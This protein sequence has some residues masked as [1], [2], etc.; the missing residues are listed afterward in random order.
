M[1][2]STNSTIA[3]IA[4]P[5]GRG[6]IGIIRV[7][8]PK[9]PDI[10]ARIVGKIPA[11]RYAQH[12][13]F[14]AQDGSVIDEGVVL[15]FPA[16]HSFTGEDVLELQGH[17]GPVV[18]DMLLKR[19]LSEG[20]EQARP[21]EF[22]ERAF[23]NGK[24]DLA[25]AEAIADLIDAQ[26]EQAARS[27][28]RSL[29]GKFSHVINQL[30]QEITQLRMYVEAAIDFPTEEIDFLAD[31]Q[32]A[33]ELEKIFASITQVEDSAQ[34]GVML[35]EGM[36]VVIAGK[37]NVGKSSLLNA[38]S[39]QDTAIVADIPG[40]TRDV[41]RAHIQI[42]GLPLHIIDTAGLRIS[43]DPVEKEGIKRAQR[44]IQQADHVMLVVDV[45]Q[46]NRHQDFI[47]D[48]SELCLQTIPAGK[49]TVVLNKI[50]V[51][52]ISP[53]V[54]QSPAGY[55]QIKLSAKS[56]EGIA[57]LRA[58]LKSCLGFN[59]TTENTFSA[60]R[61]HVDAIALAKKHVSQAKIQLHDFHAGELMAEELRLAQNALSEITGKFLPDDLLG[62]IF[63]SFCI[64]K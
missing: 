29:Q 56:G 2:S 39:G 21:G 31:Q 22:S 8:G 43:D 16:P 1:K 64:G 25:Q 61:R 15:Y 33:T 37:P 3:A 47:A 50:D 63:S 11:P 9:A 35:R 23:L 38:L 28:Q 55:A 27:A 36:S 26:S 58:H 32:I 20:V 46:E 40:T 5:P 48:L 45:T 54:T 51:M 19:I 41:L 30:V 14:L 17:G 13:V 10:A 62:K 60:R 57:L 18:L 4:T 53:E 24:M 6:G 7:S 42:D 12:A 52:H 44:E 49:I 59:A 34:Q